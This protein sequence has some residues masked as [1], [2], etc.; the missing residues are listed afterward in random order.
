WA[1]HQMPAQGENTIGVKS[2]SED[3]AEG[4]FPENR[5]NFP[6]KVGCHGKPTVGSVQ[7]GF[8]DGFVSAKTLALAFASS[9]TFQGF[10]VGPTA[11]TKTQDKQPDKPPEKLP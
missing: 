5:S 7:Q 6:K 11:R 3:N 10:R 1:E 8:C 2:F 9:R 4:L